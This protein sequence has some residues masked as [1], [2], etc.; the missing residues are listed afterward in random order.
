MNFYKEIVIGVEVQ[1]TKIDGKDKY[2]VDRVIKN[3]AGVSFS[4]DSSW[5]TKEEAHKRKADIIRL[6]E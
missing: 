6:K 2:F 3:Q 4:N 1:K 5:D